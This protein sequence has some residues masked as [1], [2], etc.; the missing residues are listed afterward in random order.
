LL[1]LSIAAF[2]PERTFLGHRPDWKQRAAESL[3]CKRVRA[4]HEAADEED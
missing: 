3:I 4:S 2:D 1:G